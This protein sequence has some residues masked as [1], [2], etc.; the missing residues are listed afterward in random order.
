MIPRRVSGSPTWAVEAKTRRCVQSA[1]S[2]PPPRAREETALI[3]GMGREES[4]ANVLLRLSRKLAVLFEELA[5]IRYSLLRG[6]FGGKGLVD[7]LLGSKS[8]PLLQVCASAER[9]IHIT[10]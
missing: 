4:S 5:S 7:E 3:V 6:L 10:G 2:R 8:L 9:A 1:N